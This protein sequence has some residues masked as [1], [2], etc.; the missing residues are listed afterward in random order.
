VEGFYKHQQLSAA[1]N[2]YIRDVL[3]VKSPEL[4]GLFD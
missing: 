2:L 4:P 1:I 3:N